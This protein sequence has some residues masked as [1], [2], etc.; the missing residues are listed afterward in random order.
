MTLVWCDGFDHYGE[1]ESNLLD[2]VYATTDGVL[3]TDHFACFW[4]IY[5]A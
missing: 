4:A 2:G 5:L 3:S 1:T